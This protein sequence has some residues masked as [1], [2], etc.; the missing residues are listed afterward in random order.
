MDALIALMAQ[1][2]GLVVLFVLAALVV[3]VGRRYVIGTIASAYDAGIGE[4]EYKVGDRFLEV[5]TAYDAGRFRD[6]V[7]KYPAA[8]KGYA[9]PVLF[10]LDYVFMFALAGLTA[11][12]SALATYYV[13][14]G[15]ATAAGLQNPVVLVCLAVA[16]AVVMPAVYLGLDIVEDGRLIAMLTKRVPVTD[17]S[18]ASVKKFTAFK[19]RSVTFAI[20]QTTVLAI[21]AAAWFVVGRLWAS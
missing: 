17:Q 3:S 9:V 13:A 4:N 16:L 6:W 15:I 1:H 2:K 8:A 19:I 11:G 20:K 21:L 12:L 5:S 14:M 18:V 7:A 10:P